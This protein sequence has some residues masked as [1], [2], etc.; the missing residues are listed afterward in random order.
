MS[1]IVCKWPTQ[2]P[3]L[4]SDV[5]FCIIF[6]NFNNV[7]ESHTISDTVTDLFVIALYIVSTSNQF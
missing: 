2:F 6:T 4:L 5:M 7:S 3:S 1:R